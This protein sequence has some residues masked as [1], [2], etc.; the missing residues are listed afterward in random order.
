MSTP[1][2]LSSILLTHD[3]FFSHRW[4]RSEQQSQV[5]PPDD[6]SAAEILAHA[7]RMARGAANR[8]AMLKPNTDY[9]F[10]LQNDDGI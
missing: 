7:Q 6:A 2:Y 5:T 8:L 3:C 9:A 10:L 1:V 4:C